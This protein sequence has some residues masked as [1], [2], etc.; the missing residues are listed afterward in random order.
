MKLR[1]VLIDD[2]EN[3]LYLL[4][5]YLKSFEKD[6]D[7][8][9]TATN[10]REAF[11][12]IRQEKPDLVF[13]DISMPGGN[14]VDLLDK[15]EKVDFQIVFITAHPGYAVEAFR[16]NAV[17][18]LLKPFEIQDL[19][20]AINRVL[21]R[22]AQSKRGYNGSENAGLRRKINIPTLQGY[23]LLEVN[24]IIRCE[25]DRSYTKVILENEKVLTVSQS[26]KVF[27]ALLN[28]YYFIRVHRSHLIS[29]ER[30]AHFS[31]GAGSEI[32]M[33]DGFKI[34]LNKD[35]KEEF[36]KLIEDYTLGKLS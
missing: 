6:I 18:Y 3:A 19:D 4:K 36:I 1:T 5:E 32:T 28:K 11:K 14:G 22:V 17:H 23:Q 15:F 8:V 12:I 16:R 31:K 9:G 7:V 29:L 26:L 13:L 10:S 20:A 25:A 27:E 2:E 30:V 24:K 33:E 35:K 21:L 34:Y